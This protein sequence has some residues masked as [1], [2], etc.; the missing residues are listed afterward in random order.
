M[1]TVPNRSRGVTAYLKH[2]SRAVRLTDWHGSTI[3]EVSG[4]RFNQ[5]RAS[6]CTSD[7]GDT[8]TPVVF[9]LTSG[10]WIAGAS[11][12]D[13][14]L[15]RG[16]LLSDYE[17]ERDALRMADQITEY[18]AGVDYEDFIRD[19]EEQAADR[20]REEQEEELRDISRAAGFIC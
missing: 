7:F 9:K 3:L 20:I 10:R 2:D 6:Y 8:L 13:G 12:G 5:S 17:E 4:Q 16:E 11:M 14:M 15:F 19:Q 1:A 18:W